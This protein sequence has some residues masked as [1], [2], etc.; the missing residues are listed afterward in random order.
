ME[1][2]NR[3]QCSVTHDT[4]QFTSKTGTI[5]E[6]PPI[7]LDKWLLAMWQVVNCRNGIGS[8]EIHRAIGVKGN[9]NACGLLLSS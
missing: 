1:K 2:Y 4:R 3:W 9:A 5:L 6:D 7:S 8:N